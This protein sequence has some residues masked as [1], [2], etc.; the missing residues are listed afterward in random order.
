MT[1]A[2][3]A[4]RRWFG[5]AT[6]QIVVLLVVLAANALLAP[7]FLDIAVRDGRLFGS[8]IDIL[9]RGAPVL[10]LACGMAVVI[11]TRGIDLSVGAVMAIAGAVAAWAI[12]AGHAWPVAIALALAS[13]ALCGL[14]N[15]VLVGVL[16]LQPIVATLILMVSGRGLAQLIT[17]GRILTF[18]EPHLAALARGDFLGLPNPAVIAFAVVL[19]TLALARLT[20]LGLFIEAAGVN[21]EASRLSGVATRGVTVFVYVWSGLMAGLAGLIVTA[22]IQGA[23]AN[24]AGLWL[25]LDAILAAVIGGISLFGG[26]FSLS[27][28][29]LGALTLQALKTGILRSGL[30]PEMNLVVMAIVVAVVLILQAPAIA[31]RIER[32]K[33][34]RGQK[35]EGESAA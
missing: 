32:W 30:P 6:P 34:N 19:G 33:L 31:E 15:G 4:T 16:R 11:A 35:R 7:G 27:R 3:K 17:E 20:G 29:I 12:Q 10:L 22:D 21:P 9:N 13:G 8:L 25:E 5:E 2:L 28:V 18:V 14:W 24:N 23:D 1:G 26:R